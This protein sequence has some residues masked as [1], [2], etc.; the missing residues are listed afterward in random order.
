VDTLAYRHV[1][2]ELPR[3]KVEIGVR[4]LKQTLAEMGMTGV[5]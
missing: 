3:F 2:L 5:V 1:E 4:S